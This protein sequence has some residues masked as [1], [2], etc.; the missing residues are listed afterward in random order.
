MRLLVLIVALWSAAAVVVAL[1]LGRILSGEPLRPTRHQQALALGLG[2]VGAALV[3]FGLAAPDLR[4]GTVEPTGPRE[5]SPELRP[6]QRPDLGARGSPGSAPGISAALAAV[7][8]LPPR[9]GFAAAGTVSGGGP[10]ATAG[11]ASAGLPGAVSPPPRRRPRRSA[12]A[13]PGRGGPIPVAAARPAAPAPPARGDD[14]EGQRR[15]GRDDDDEG[16]RR[17]GRRHDEGRRGRGRDEDEGRR[18]RGRGDGDD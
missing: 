5:T 8:A 1:V 14:D 12:P 7:A 18:G 16:R 11:P 15:R 13:P 2:A 6:A 9:A 10:P 17:R 3:V 4:E